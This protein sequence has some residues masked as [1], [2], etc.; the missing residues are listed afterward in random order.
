ML[1]QKPVHVSQY[2]A[3]AA[4]LVRFQQRQFLNSVL[5]LIMKKLIPA[6]SFGFEND[7]TDNKLSIARSSA[8]LQTLVSIEN[9]G[10]QE[11]LSSWLTRGTSAPFALFR[12]SLAVLPEDETETVLQKSWE[13]FGDKL[14]VRHG[15]VIQQEGSQIGAV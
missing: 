13:Q 12:A 8:M 15:P 1:F 3:L 6:Q 11:H 2:Q 4:Q 5:G 7:T 9:S 10:Y 14:F